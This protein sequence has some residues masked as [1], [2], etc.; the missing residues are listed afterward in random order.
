MPWPRRKRFRLNMMVLLHIGGTDPAIGPAP[1]PV[2]QRQDDGLQNRQWR[3]D[4][5]PAC[6]F[7]VRGRA[8]PSAAPSHRTAGRAGPVRPRIGSLPFAFV[9]QRIGRPPPEREATGSN[10][11]EGTRV[12]AVTRPVP[13]GRVTRTHGP[14]PT[15]PGGVNGQHSGLPCR[16]SG[17][18]SRPGLAWLRCFSQQSLT[19]SRLVSRDVKVSDDVHV[20]PVHAGLIHSSSA[21]TTQSTTAV[22][23]VRRG[24]RHMKT[25]SDTRPAAVSG[26]LVDWP[27]G[28]RHRPAKAVDGNSVSRVRIPHQPP[29]PAADTMVRARRGVKN[30]RVRA[31]VW[32]VSITVARTANAR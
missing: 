24:R 22:R 3:F 9:A 5:S 8:T 7:P 11:V 32:Q 16:R 31:N 17:F 20:F 10:P 30:G 26:Q 15:R 12:R 28:L 14:A 29:D 18:E 13:R 27:S 4:S 6:V 1:A 23:A 25:A 21:T 2:V 19:W